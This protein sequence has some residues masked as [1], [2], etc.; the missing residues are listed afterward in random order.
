MLLD[1]A[2]SN[3]E[4]QGVLDGV[5]TVGEIN[6]V[7]AGGRLQPGHATQPGRLT[8]QSLD[9]SS[10]T[11]FG[12]IVNGSIAG[13]GYSQLVV[14]GT[15]TLGGAALDLTIS[16]TFQSA[17]AGNEL[18]LIDNDGTD[19][20][21]DTFAGLAEGAIITGPGGTQFRLSYVGGTGN[22]VTLTP[23]SSDYFLSEGSTGSFFDT[24]ALIANP[25]PT[26]APVTIKFL[27]DD[28]TTVSQ[29]RT[30]AATSRT[31]IHVNDQPGMNATAFSTVV[32][33]LGGLPLVV[34]RTMSWD[35]TGYGG[36]G[37]KATAGAASTWYFAEGSQGF[38]STF[39]LLMNPQDTANTAVVQ[40]LVEGAPPVLRSYAMAATSRLTV[41]IGSEPALQS[42][43]FGMIVNFETPGWP[44]GRCT[45]APIPSGKAGTNQRA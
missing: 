22:D 16:P 9:L 1:T 3:G 42:R 40:Y 7:G 2:T 39:L 5:G 11:T 29:D 41:D 27:K 15:V 35:K 32:T 43:S 28:G 19:P 18:I 31:T 26:A 30:L 21:E 20:I 36:H 10:T 34:E 33:S 14:K 44:N 17:S 6:I 8:S 23:R 37:E 13:T 45:S 24:D 12:A 4:K 25:N 38:Y